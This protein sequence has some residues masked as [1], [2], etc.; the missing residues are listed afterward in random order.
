MQVNKL[1]TT[2]ENKKKSIVQ[3]AC[4][5]HIQYLRHKHFTITSKIKYG[6]T[7][8]YAFTWQFKN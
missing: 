1:N 4:I 3:Q 8:M 5:I 7:I 6:F 2:K